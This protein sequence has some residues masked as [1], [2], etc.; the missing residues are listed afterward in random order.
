MPKKEGFQPFSYLVGVGHRMVPLFDG[1]PKEERSMAN[2]EQELKTGTIA[3]R[4]QELRAYGDKLLGM[5]ESH[6]LH[7]YNFHDRA[8]LLEDVKKNRSKYVMVGGI[9]VGG[10]A[11]AAILN[12]RRKKRDKAKEKTIFQSRKDGTIETQ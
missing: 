3:Q 10:V 8:Q 12:E 2:L 9:I 11:A 7:L 4:A 6:N 1:K 5:T